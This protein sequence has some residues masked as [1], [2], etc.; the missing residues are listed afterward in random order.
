[1]RT[2]AHVLVVEDDPTLRA[3]Y[4][5]IL[6][7][8][9]LDVEAA[10]DRDE[11]LA[12]IMRRTYNVAL[13]DI[14]LEGPD[15]DDRGGF[16]VMELIKE[17]G[18][19]TQIIVLSGAQTPEVP[20]ESLLKYQAHGYIM[21]PIR[22]KEEILDPLAAA[23]EIQA[24]RRYGDQPN[25]ITYLAGEEREALWVSSALRTLRPSNG[26]AGLS[27]FLSRFLSPLT[28]LLPSRDRSHICEL[29]EEKEQLEGH[30]WSKGIGNEV[31]FFVRHKE[32][33][34]EFE[35]PDL[36]SGP[37]EAFSRCSKAGLEGLAIEVKNGKRDEFV[38]GFKRND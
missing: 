30:A 3:Q 19:G 29:N 37:L 36:Q 21:K 35:V 9:D 11:A 38:R 8:A 26:Y 10:G 20:V 34:R 1:M 33:G 7:D 32:E 4:T 31:A 13:V 17:L 18:E 12:C 27:I 25:V 5:R 15:A 24:I 2:K 23:L 22:S 14:M 6:T 28:P 16:A